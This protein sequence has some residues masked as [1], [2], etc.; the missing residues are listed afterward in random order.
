MRLWG[1]LCRAWPYIVVVL[2][3]APGTSLQCLQHPA[4]SSPQQPH[5][6]TKCL[7]DQLAWPH[8]ALLPCSVLLLLLPPSCSLQGHVVSVAY[9]TSG[10]I[11]VSDD[12][13]LRF[14]DFAVGY[15][16]LAGLVGEGEGMQQLVATGQRIRGFLD[17]KA[18]G[19]PDTAG[20]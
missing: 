20:G 16:Q 5:S 2:H 18:P 11:A 9:Q 17:A 4:Q 10:S 12:D 14:A 15:A 7:P 3:H 8:A 1:L 13:A 19:G 6:S